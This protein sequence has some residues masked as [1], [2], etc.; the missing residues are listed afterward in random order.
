MKKADVIIGQRYAA[1]VSGKIAHVR[2]VRESPYGG[3]DAINVATGRQV[4]I[5][6]AARLRYNVAPLV[7]PPSDSE[8]Q[9]NRDTISRQNAALNKWAQQFFK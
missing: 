1:K 8:G 7:I 9:A 6:T 4:R 2:I 3:W 5:K